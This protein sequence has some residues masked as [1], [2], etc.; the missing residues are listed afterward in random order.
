[1]DKLWCIYTAVKK[2]NV[3]LIHRTTQTTQTVLC[4]MKETS[5][6]TTYPV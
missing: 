6:K 5:Y 4:G 2:S 1:M 3:L